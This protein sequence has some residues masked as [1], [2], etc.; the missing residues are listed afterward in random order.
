MPPLSNKNRVKKPSAK[1][2]T[3]KSKRRNSGAAFNRLRKVIED[4]NKK[5][6]EETEAAL[7]ENSIESAN[8]ATLTTTHGSVNQSGLSPQCPVNDSTPAQDHVNQFSPSHKDTVNRTTTPSRGSVD[9]SG[10]SPG[11][12]GINFKDAPSDPEELGAWTGEMINK[13]G[14]DPGSEK[15]EK[16]DT[17]SRSRSPRTQNARMRGGGQYSSKEGETRKYRQTQMS[18]SK[19]KCQSCCL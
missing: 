4:L 7:E 8:G 2:E 14:K 10:L 11:N 1:P 12:S 17:M 13:L 19:R 16:D 3:Q 18:S 9:Q 15:I 5:R 6:K